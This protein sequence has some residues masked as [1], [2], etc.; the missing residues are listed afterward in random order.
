MDDFFMRL[1]FA[2]RLEYKDMDYYTLDDMLE[3]HFALDLQDEIQRR[4]EAKVRD[5]T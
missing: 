5:K 2:K 4:E 1:W 3:M